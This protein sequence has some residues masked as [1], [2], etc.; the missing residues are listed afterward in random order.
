MIGAKIPL[1]P[2]Q[3]YPFVRS[4]KPRGRVLLD[5]LLFPL[6][7]TLPNDLV[8]QLGLTSITEERLRAIL[9][10]LRGRI[11]DVGCGL[12][13]LVQLAGGGIGIDVYPWPAVDLLADGGCLP[14]RDGAFD[15]VVFSATLNHIPRRL[16]ALREARRVLRT[17]GVVLVTMINPVFGWVGHEIL[18]RAYDEHRERGMSDGETFGLWRGDIEALVREA[19]LMLSER[20]CFFYRLNCLYVCEKIHGERLSSFRNDHES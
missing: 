19:G 3:K 17:D 13:E 16:D 18:W 4:P 14:F 1:P 11:L 2:S 12:N 8:I 9:P 5:L 7:M 15:T 20:I 10:H 6:R